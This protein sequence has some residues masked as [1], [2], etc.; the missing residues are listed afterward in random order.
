MEQV[1]ERADVPLPIVAQRARST[2]GVVWRDVLCGELP[3]RKRG[4]RWFV[5][6]DAA[7]KYIAQR[8]E[9]SAA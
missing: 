7:D 2:W 9:S 6:A 8:L 4:G 1:L 5:P 3:A